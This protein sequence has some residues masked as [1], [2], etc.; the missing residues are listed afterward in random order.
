MAQQVVLQGEGFPPPG[1]PSEPHERRI[2]RTELYLPTSMKAAL[3]QLC[4][5]HGV[6]IN[7]I[8][9]RFFKRALAGQTPTLNEIIDEARKAHPARGTRPKEVRAA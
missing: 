4:R 1:E 2:Q 3:V 6:S 7:D 8:A 9:V 5:E